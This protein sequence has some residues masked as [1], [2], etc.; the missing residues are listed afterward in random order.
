MGVWVGVGV[1]VMVGVGVWVGVWVCV[2]VGVGVLVF[3][4]ISMIV[5]IGCSSIDSLDITALLLCVVLY[6]SRMCC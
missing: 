4:C 2:G 6:M 5:F 1:W 3:M